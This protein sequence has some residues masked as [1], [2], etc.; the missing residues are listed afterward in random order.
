MRFFSYPGCACIHIKLLIWSHEWACVSDR[1]QKT[2]NPYFFS[3]NSCS[4]NNVKQHQKHENKSAHDLCRPMAVCVLNC[5]WCGVFIIHWASKCGS[6]FEKA[7]NCDG[8]AVKP[9]HTA[10]V[11]ALQHLREYIFKWSLS[12]THHHHRIVSPFSVYHST[13]T[14]PA[15][16]VCSFELWVATGHDGNVANW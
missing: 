6:I 3:V 11:G 12:S 4:L 7:H 9:T 13:D 2:I 1:W 15:R 8:R 14:N 5:G 10:T 16:S